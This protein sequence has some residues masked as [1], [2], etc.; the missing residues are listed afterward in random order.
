MY[1]THIY[2]HVYNLTYTYIC[3]MGTSQNMHKNQMN[4]KHFLAAMVAH[5]LLY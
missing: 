3:L 2:I 1:S 4:L 5:Q